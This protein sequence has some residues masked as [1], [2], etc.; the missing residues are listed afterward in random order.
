MRTIILLLCLLP[1]AGSAQTKFAPIGAKWT[2]MQYGFLGMPPDSSIVVVECIGDTIIQGRICS[3]L[4]LTGTTGCMYFHEHVT[5]SGDSIFFHDPVE[6]R[7]MLMYIMGAPVGTTWE[8]V[9]SREW[10]DLGELQVQHDTL[11]FSVTESDTMIIDGVE[12]RRIHVDATPTFEWGFANYPIPG[13]IVE[14]LGHLSY[15]FPWSDAACDM[16]GVGPLRCYEDPDVQWLNPQFPHCELSVDVAGTRAPVASFHPNLL[17]AGGYLLIIPATS[18]PMKYAVH[19]AVGG[20]VRAGTLI[21][22]TSIHMERAGIHHLTLWL[23]D[24]RRLYQKVI[25]Q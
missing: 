13:T 10:W 19:D 17:E 8:T 1:V 4:A 23:E 16:E 9:L 11:L 2:Y 18:G 15:V 6:D 12:L 25:V 3:K 21:G 14:R 20:L 24:G 5:A 22:S 7:F